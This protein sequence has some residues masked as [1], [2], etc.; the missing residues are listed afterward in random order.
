[1]F[2][3][4]PVYPLCY[5]L[6]LVCV[7]KTALTNILI[8]LTITAS[9]QWKPVCPRIFWPEGLCEPSQRLAD[10]AG[11][12]GKRPIGPFSLVSSH[13][14]KHQHIHDYCQNSKFIM[15]ICPW[16]WLHYNFGANMLITWY[17]PCRYSLIF[18]L[19]I[20]ILNVS[21]KQLANWI[22]EWMSQIILNNKCLIQYVCQSV[23]TK[24]NPYIVL[25]LYHYNWIAVGQFFGQ[26]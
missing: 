22:D 10:F 1:M 25:I 6:R 9:L 24:N 17:F 21:L 19:L 4:E 7:T 8:I 14:F 13:F 12:R 16:M 11:A 3:W 26:T 5:A 23:H 15:I 20:L 2:S 18:S